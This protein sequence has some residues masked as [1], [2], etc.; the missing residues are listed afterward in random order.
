MRI[1]RW[2]ENPFSFL[3]PGNPFPCRWACGRPRAGRKGFLREWATG[4]HRASF[5]G[6]LSSRTSG[7]PTDHA[8]ERS[9]APELSGHFPIGYD[10]QPLASFVVRSPEQEFIAVSSR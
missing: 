5:S 6:T 8:Q 2:N 7:H 9:C 3:V 1:C 4:L 10:R